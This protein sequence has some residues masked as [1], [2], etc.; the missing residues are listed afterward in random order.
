MSQAVAGHGA[1]IAIESYPVVAGAFEVVAE[2]NGDIGF[3]GLNR[4]ETEVT[5]H[6]DTIDSYVMGRLGRDQLTFS[7]NYVYND[8]THDHLTGLQ[9]HLINNS[10]FGVRI[11]GPQGTLANDGSDEIIASGHVQSFKHTSPVREGVRTAEVVIRLSKAFIV[12]G[13]EHG[14]TV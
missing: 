6:Q 7:V 4:P 14:T 12:D 8:G 5:P 10:F 9:A 13:E 1:T 11:R 3:P 2:L